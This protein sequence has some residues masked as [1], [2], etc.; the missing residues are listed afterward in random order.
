MQGANAGSRPSNSH[1]RRRNAGFTL[2]ELLVVIAIIAVLMAL[3]LPAVQQAREA[4]RRT[5]CLNNLHQLAL[6][7][8]NYLSAYRTFPPGWICTGDVSPCGVEGIL[9]EAPCGVPPTASQCSITFPR[10]IGSWVPFGDQAKIGLNAAAGDMDAGTSAVVVPPGIPWAFSELWSWQPIILPQVDALSV[11]VNF[12]APKTTPENIAAIQTPLSTFVCPS[13]ALP[14]NRP[15]GLGYVNY[16]GSMGSGV[17]MSSVPTGAMTEAK[18][19][20]TTTLNY[21]NGMLY[22]NSA[23]SDRDVVDGLTTTLLFAETQYGFWG[24]A[25]SA[26]TRLPG[27]TEGQSPFDW[28]SQLQSFTCKNDQITR[29]YYTFGFG[30]WHAGLINVA[31]ADGSARSLSKGTD[32]TV[33][34][35]LG[36]RNGHEMVSDNF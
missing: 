26:A 12:Q 32:L 2:N 3:L 18:I 27:P 28:H 5:Q 14:A 22:K 8:T 4:A 31:L 21:T 29:K 6:A 15:G 25:M 1:R 7:A 16:T 11:R 35:A 20:V 23:V 34:D 13:A 17:G 10:M 19:P 30:S 24:D 33:L 9:E 36:S